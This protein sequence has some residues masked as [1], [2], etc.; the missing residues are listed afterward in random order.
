M[1]HSAVEYYGLY[2]NTCTVLFKAKIKTCRGLLGVD[3]L[4]KYMGLS[5]LL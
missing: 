3:D 4:R 5:E 1:V 2:E